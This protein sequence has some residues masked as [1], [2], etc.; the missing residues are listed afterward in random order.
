MKKQVT[1]KR[2]LSPAPRKPT[3]KGLSGWIQLWSAARSS[4]S[5][6]FPRR[7]HLAG[8]D[9]GVPLWRCCA[10]RTDPDFD[11]VL[12]A[13]TTVDHRDPAG[14]DSTLSDQIVHRA[15]AQ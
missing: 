6:A 7:L 8:L 10:R 1:A 4:G 3:F 12:G 13:I 11:N 9:S 14:I 5:S 2:A 15:P